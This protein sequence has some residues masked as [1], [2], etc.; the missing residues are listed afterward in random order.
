M[1]LIFALL[2][3][4]RKDGQ[5]LKYK[6]TESF[7]SVSRSIKREWSVEEA[8]GTGSSRMAFERHNSAIGLNLPIGNQFDS[9]ASASILEYW[10]PCEV[11]PETL[12]G[13]L[14]TMNG[15]SMY[16]AMKAFT[17]DIYRPLRRQDS[18]L[19]TQP[20]P[21]QEPPNFVFH[22][23]EDLQATPPPSSPLAP[24]VLR[25][26][27]EIG[28]GAVGSAY[29]GFFPGVS[30]P[31]VVKILPVD[32]MDR[33]LE[34]WRR[35][36]HLAG[37]TIPGLYGAYAIDNK[38]GRAPTGALVQQHAGSTLASFENLSSDQRLELYAM[39]TSIHV[40]QVNTGT[41]DLQ[42]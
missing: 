18:S 23:I 19:W 21:S 6:A 12:A 10:E 30:V 36:R 1:P 15:L 25:L 26:E 40:A 16:W 33:E 5:A 42:M 11:A 32:C 39:V 3:H 13:L 28:R 14:K 37:I 4:A 9:A 7:A 35:L 8:V 38:T 29:R 24:F 20:V 27:D 2:L 31:I 22:I 34:I 41:S 17:E